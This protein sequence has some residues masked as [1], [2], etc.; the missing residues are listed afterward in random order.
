MTHIRVCEADETQRQDVESF[1]K[2]S[3]CLKNPDNHK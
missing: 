2:C 3:N 1:Y